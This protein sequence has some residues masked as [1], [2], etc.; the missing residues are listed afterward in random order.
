MTVTS[1]IIVMD[2]GRLA[3]RASDPAVRQPAS[4]R[5]S[6]FLHLDLISQRSTGSLT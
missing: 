2:L 1:L 3:E 5:F 6:N 4:S